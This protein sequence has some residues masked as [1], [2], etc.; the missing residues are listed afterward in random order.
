[1]DAPSAGQIHIADWGA[2]N[3]QSG[4]GCSKGLARVSI[5][6]LFAGCFTMAR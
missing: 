2:M 6:L 5:G 3:Q 4:L 1:M